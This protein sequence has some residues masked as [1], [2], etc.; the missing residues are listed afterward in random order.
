MR[1]GEPSCRR[2]SVPRKITEW[3]GGQN[4]S[5]APHVTGLAQSRPLQAARAM[6]GQLRF[7][8]NRRHPLPLGLPELLLSQ[9]GSCGIAEQTNPEA[10]AQPWGRGVL[11][12]IRESGGNCASPG[13]SEACERPRPG[14]PQILCPVGREDRDASPQRSV[15]RLYPPFTFH[16]S[17]SLTAS[18][19]LPIL[20][21]LTWGGAQRPR[22]P[23]RALAASAP[24]GS[25]PHAPGRQSPCPPRPRPP[26]PPPPQPLPGAVLRSQP[27]PS[28]AQTSE[29]GPAPSHCRGRGGGAPATGGGRA[30]GDCVPGGGVCS[31]A[32]P[33]GRCHGNA[34]A[35][36]PRARTRIVS[37]S[38]LPCT[39]LGWGRRG[40]PLGPPTPGG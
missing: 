10:P 5:Q 9:G 28:P 37:A 14:M 24:L 19:A 11:P 2:D 7:S 17:F 26:P 29:P 40:A 27:S 31:G 20:R 1:C 6:N 13:P 30:G 33:M 35:P 23:L 36:A 21:R 25:A 39:A 22:S 32:R 34:P 15:P 18:S 38:R 3:G 16:S 12:P 4:R 8:R